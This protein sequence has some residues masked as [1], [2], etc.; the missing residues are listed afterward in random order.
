MTEDPIGPTVA[1]RIAKS[2]YLLASDVRVEGRK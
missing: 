2:M 1:A